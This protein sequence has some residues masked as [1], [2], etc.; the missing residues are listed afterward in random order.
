MCTHDKM[1]NIRI[2]QCININYNMKM[3][4]LYHNL[5]HN[6]NKDVIF[7]QNIFFLRKIITNKIYRSFS[8]SSIRAN[9]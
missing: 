7:K 3:Y 4:L 9:F 5:H 6:N 1:L 2:K 8:H